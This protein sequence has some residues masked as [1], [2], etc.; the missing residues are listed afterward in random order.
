KQ[1]K[2]SGIG[3]SGAQQ[4]NRRDA[5]ALLVDL[6]AESHGAGVSAAHIGM[7]SA[8][9]YVKVGTTL[10]VRSSFRCVHKYWSHEGDVGQVSSAA[11]GIVEDDHVAIVHGT[12]F[13][14]RCGRQGH[15]S[16]MHGHV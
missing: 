6:A 12:G 5:N 2:N 10:R 16:E 7:V 14:C 11:K 15:G 3:G 4:F 1:G 9:G 8:R 13:N